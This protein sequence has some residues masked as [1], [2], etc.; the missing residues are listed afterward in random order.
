MTFRLTKEEIY[1]VEPSPTPVSQATKVVSQGVKQ[2]QN[3]PPA[4]ICPIVYLN[5]IH[6]KVRQDGRVINKTTYLA[7]GVNIEGLK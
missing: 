7:I 6:I 5:A 3:R 1:G 4:E 2:W